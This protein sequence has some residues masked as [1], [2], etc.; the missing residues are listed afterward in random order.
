RMLKRLGY[1]ADVAVNGLEAVKAARQCNYDVILM[2]IQMPEMDGLQA[3]RQ[4][5]STLTTPDQPYIIA[6]TAATLQSDQETCFTAGMDDFV[7]KPARLEDLAQALKRYL[8]LSTAA[9]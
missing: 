4:I 8:R 2:D 9:Y 3:T 7:A 5:R 1:E 6:M